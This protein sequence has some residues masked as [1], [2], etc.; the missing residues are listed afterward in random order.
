[1]LTILAGVYTK[2]E[3]E[4]DVRE[5]L[6]DLV[7]FGRPFISN[8]DL[9]ERLKNDWPLTAP[10]HSTFYGG[11]RVGYIDYPVYETSAV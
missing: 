2:E 7:A 3:G 11:D 1:M 6:T 8:P 4:R 5:G 9:V 10:D